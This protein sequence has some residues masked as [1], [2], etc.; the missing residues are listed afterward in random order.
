M[1]ATRSEIRTQIRQ[2]LNQTSAPST[3]LWSDTQI[4]QKIT[5]RIRRLNRFF[6]IGAIDTSL[7]TSSCTVEYS[8]PTGVVRIN[9]IEMWDLYNT[10]NTNLGE[11]LNWK[12]FNDAGTWKIIFP[13]ELSYSSDNPTAYTLKLF[14]EKRLTEPSADGTSLDCQLEEEELIVVCASMDCLRD[15]FRSRVDM[16]RYLVEAIGT[17]GSTIDIARAINEYHA[18]YNEI[19]N[20]LKRSKAQKLSFGL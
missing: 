20:E 9:K 7:A 1:S 16:T 12:T 17:G 2:N 5:N 18:Q 3:G 19:F 11:I 13:Q 8:F 15:L 14:C 6:R 10:P 4:N